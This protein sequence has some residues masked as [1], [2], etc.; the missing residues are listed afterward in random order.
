MVVRIGNE[1]ASLLL[2][3]IWIYFFSNCVLGL[4]LTVV[5]QVH[6]LQEKVVRPI[7]ASDGEA[8]GRQL[9]V[10]GAVMHHDSLIG[11][12]PLL[13]G[14][15][16]ETMPDPSASD[17]ILLFLVD[18]PPDDADVV[19]GGGEEV[20]GSLVGVEYRVVLAERPRALLDHRL[21][22]F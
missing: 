1:S 14:D 16:L 6:H 21:P 9:V 5:I 17:H 8:T 2:L 20:F 18:V 13:L 7:V 12:R 19:A 3:P 4:S 11:I 22:L 15:D 10:K